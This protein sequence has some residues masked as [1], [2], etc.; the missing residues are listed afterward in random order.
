MNAIGDCRYCT[1]TC[2]L[3]VYFMYSPIH[4]VCV[5][6]ETLKRL[7]TIRGLHEVTM[8]NKGE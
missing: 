2:T 5:C 4:F 8:S 6:G 1:Y 3:C 7:F